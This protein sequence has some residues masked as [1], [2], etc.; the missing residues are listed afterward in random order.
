[1]ISSISFCG[2]EECLSKPVKELKNIKPVQVFSEFTP[3]GLPQEKASAVRELKMA[4]PE[5]VK[6][7]YFSPFNSTSK[8]KEPVEEI[9]AEEGRFFG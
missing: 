7:N 6:A 4:S 8:V 1:M 3:H 5:A 2:R 9:I